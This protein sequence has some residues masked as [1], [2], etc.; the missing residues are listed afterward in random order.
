MTNWMGLYAE[1]HDDWVDACEREKSAN[2]WL[3]AHKWLFL[4]TAFAIGTVIG[5]FL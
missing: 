2:R 5:H 3:L 4:P 1:V